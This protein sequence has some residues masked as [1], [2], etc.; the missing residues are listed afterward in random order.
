VDNSAFSPT[1]LTIPLDPVYPSFNPSNR[2]FSSREDSDAPPCVVTPARV[3]PHALPA[4]ALFSL[5]APSWSCPGESSEDAQHA[6]SPAPATYPTRLSG[7]SPFRPLLN[8]CET[9][10]SAGASLVRGLKSARSSQTHRNA[11]LRL[12]QSAVFVLWY[13]RRSHPCSRRGWQAWLC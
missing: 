7:L 9:I 12:S 11:R 2:P 5:L 1:G 3:L 13:H 10:T 4:P 6:P 8:G